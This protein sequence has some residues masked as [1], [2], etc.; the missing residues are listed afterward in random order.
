M[1]TN[2]IKALW[3]DLYRLYAVRSGVKLGARAS[4]VGGGGVTHDAPPCTAVS[5]VRTKPLEMRFSSEQIVTDERLLLE[6]YWVPMSGT[7]GAEWVTELCA[8]GAR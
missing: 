2:P 5:G 3:Q 1:A 6:K 4:D 7:T 8:L